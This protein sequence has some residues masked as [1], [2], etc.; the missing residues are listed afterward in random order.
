VLDN[1]SVPPRFH[2]PDAER[3]GD[4]VR[5]PRDEAEHLVRV[6]RL[7]PG[8]AVRVF[9]GRGAEFDAA[10]DVVTKSGAQ[11]RVD[12]QRDPQ[13]EARVA[14]T[15]VQAVL[16]G[17]KMDHVVRDAV[18][19]GVVMVQP[20]VTT[21]SEV[22]LA[23]LRRGHRQERWQRI[24]VSS[25]KQCGRAVV[26]MVG[27]PCAFE[28]MAVALGKTSPPGQTLMFV[29]PSASARVISLG[30]LG[31][32]PPH[33]STILAGPEGGWTPGEVERGSVVGRLVTL[34][35]HT[36]RADAI[37]LVAVTALLTHWREL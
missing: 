32:E 10:V 14:V 13:P 34:G 22:A 35:N 6:L 26:P 31:A 5:L 15:L 30:D 23:S 36:L 20:V 2:A 33:A 37:A 7:K 8:T 1:R 21:R 17:D 16:K 18:M 12:A 28:E 24:A 9:N 25:A 27:M 19:M 3:P 11:I 4:V 29:E